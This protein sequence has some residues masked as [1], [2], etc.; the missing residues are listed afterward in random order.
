MEGRHLGC[1]N[2]TCRVLQTNTVV[3]H[4][5]DG[6][7]LEPVRPIQQCVNCRE[8]QH[9]LKLPTREQKAKEWRASPTV[10]YQFNESFSAIPGFNPHFFAD[11]ML[12]L[13]L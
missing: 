10:F 1:R 6:Q 13:Q 11:S 8:L 7:I 9:S 12:P 3:D 5:A 4:A 2:S